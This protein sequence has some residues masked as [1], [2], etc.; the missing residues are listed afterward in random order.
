MSERLIDRLTNPRPDGSH[1][2]DILPIEFRFVDEAEGQRLQLRD[3]ECVSE[4]ECG[5]I[6]FYTYVVRE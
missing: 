4:R 3:A 2:E 5:R 1:P 6:K